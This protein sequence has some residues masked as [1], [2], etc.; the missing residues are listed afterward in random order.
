M[1]IEKNYSFVFRVEQKKGQFRW[2]LFLRQFVIAN[3]EA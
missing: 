2:E 3:G 1:N